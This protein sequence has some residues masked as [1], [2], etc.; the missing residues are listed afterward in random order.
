MT[1]KMVYAKVNNDNKIIVKKETL[2]ESGVSQSEEIPTSVETEDN[3]P[4]RLK[5]YAT[6]S[7]GNCPPRP[8]DRFNPSW[9]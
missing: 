6:R 8:L 9:T 1:T 4:S 5:E 3:T 7:Q 2:L